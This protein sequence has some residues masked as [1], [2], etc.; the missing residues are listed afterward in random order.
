M[1][2]NSS[3]FKSTHHICSALWYFVAT[4]FLLVQLEDMP[5]ASSRTQNGFGRVQR[6]MDGM[7]RDLFSRPR[8]RN[9]IRV[10][11]VLGANVDAQGIH[12][13]GK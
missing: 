10:G 3:F 9:R 12:N 4:Q 13:G 5:R 2:G 1:G 7:N 11:G 8:G 6:W